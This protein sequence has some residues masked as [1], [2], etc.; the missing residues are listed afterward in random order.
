MA[1]VLARREHLTHGSPLRSS[2]IRVQRAGGSPEVAGH[3]PPGVQ[4]HTGPPCNQSAAMVSTLCGQIKGPV[5]S[6]SRPLHPQVQRER[7]CVWPRST[8][9]P[10]HSTHGFCV[11]LLWGSGRHPCPELWDP[12]SL[13]PH[14][15]GTEAA[16]LSRNL[17]AQGRFP[18]TRAPAVPAQCGWGTGA[19]QRR[20]LGQRGFQQSNLESVMDHTLPGQAAVPEGLDSLATLQAA[21][22]GERVPLRPRSPC[23]RA[24][25]MGGQD[26]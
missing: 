2:S 17:G 11:A 12:V 19:R 23:G 20:L 1:R 8:Q 10:W 24:P 7:P 22:Q 6:R 26:G 9:S 18:P 14:Q 16:S 25:A 4:P 21:G 3:P 15:L 13:H 5:P